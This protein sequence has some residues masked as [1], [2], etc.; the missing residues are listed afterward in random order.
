MYICVIHALTLAW[1]IPGSSSTSGT[2]ETGGGGGGGVDGRG[3]GVDGLGG[4]GQ[5]ECDA[6]VPTLFK[7]LPVTSLGGAMATNLTTPL[8]NPLII[9]S[10]VATS[11]PISDVSLTERRW[12]PTL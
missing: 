12:S 4:G 6:G 11:T 7:P 1:T 10:A 9:V 8:D 3:G 5:V 2:G